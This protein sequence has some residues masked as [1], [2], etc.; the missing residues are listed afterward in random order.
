MK[1]WIQGILWSFCLTL[2]IPGQTQ[3]GFVSDFLLKWENAM[4]YTLEFAEAM[5]EEHYSYK[6]MPEQ[7]TFAQQLTHV[8]G[9]MVWLSTAYLGGTGFAGD[10]D[11]LPEDKE[12][13]MRLV[14]AAFEY[15]AAT[16]EDFDA[17][18]LDDMIDFF[19]GP[20]SKRRVFVLI[21]DH[22]THHR[23]QLVVYLRL[24]GIEPPRYRGW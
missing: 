11:N 7:R 21:N 9:N 8:A 20:M 23:G 18:G 19:A 2:A 12:E 10:L 5:P 24:K 15:T 16:A 3:D 14:R 4:E 6:P 1:I 13:V 17:T 22:V